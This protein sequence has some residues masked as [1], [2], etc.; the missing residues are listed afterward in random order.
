MSDEFIER[1]AAKLGMT[2]AEF[3]PVWA[4][5]CEEMFETLREGLPVDLGFSYINLTSA[6]PRR[7]YDLRAQTTVVAPTRLKLRFTVPPHVNHCLGNQEKL[8]W[9]VFLTRQQLKAL[10]EDKKRELDSAG[11]KYY[12][13]KG[14]TA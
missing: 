12:D 14:V 10:P 3:G 13:L 5:M 6:A 11:L 9:A 8:S 1:A 7:R 2:P 4:A